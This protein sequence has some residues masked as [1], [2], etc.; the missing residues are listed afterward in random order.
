VRAVSDPDTQRRRECSKLT[1]T[2]DAGSTA[3]SAVTIAVADTTAPA[4]ALTRAV[5]TPTA[6]DNVGV[7]RVQWYF[8][9]GLAATATAAPFPFTLD[10]AP[11]PG[12]HTLVARAF[13]AAGNTTD[14]APISIGP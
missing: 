12:P 8:D 14:S 2:D 9:G 5:F 10:L 7:V 13:D 4:I 11:G 3:T 6:S 1:V